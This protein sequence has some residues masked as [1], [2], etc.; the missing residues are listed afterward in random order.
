MAAP[1]PS[2]KNPFASNAATSSAASAPESGSTRANNARCAD[3]CCTRSQRAT[4]SEGSWEGG[5]VGGRGRFAS[6][7]YSCF[8]Y[9]GFV[10]VVDDYSMGVYG[11]R[12]FHVGQGLRWDFCTQ[13]WFDRFFVANGPCFVFACKI[14][15]CNVTVMNYNSHHNTPSFIICPYGLTLPMKPGSPPVW[16]C[17]IPNNL[18]HF[19][20]R[21]S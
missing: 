1:R 20:L 6:F 10:F 14:D 9:R 8:S 2:T 21:S 7:S 19:W 4:F 17:Q 16:R 11:L 12:C 5:V 3:K 13:L 18:N 15:T